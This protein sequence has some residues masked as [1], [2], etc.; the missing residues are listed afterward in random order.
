[1]ALLVWMYLLSVTALIGCEY[2][3]ERERLEAAGL[4]V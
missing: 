4:P 2:N 3:A 1:V